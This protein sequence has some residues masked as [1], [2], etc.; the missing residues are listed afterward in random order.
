MRDPHQSYQ[1]LAVAGKNQLELMLLLYDGAIGFLRKARPCIR[2]KRIEEAH[3]NLMKAKRI[4][5]HLC[6][7]I[8]PPA[9]PP[10][11]KELVEGLQQLYLFCYERIGMANLKKNESNLDAA[12]CVLEMLREGWCELKKSGKWQPEEA[13]PVFDK[14]TINIAEA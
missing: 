9:V 2:E 11:G 4:V 3:N 12:L 7:T 13:V 10:D 14:S 8:D 1:N 5:A 6:T